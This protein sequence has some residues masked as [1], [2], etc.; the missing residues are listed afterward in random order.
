M[1]MRTADTTLTYLVSGPFLLIIDVHVAHK[2]SAAS[3]FCERNI[4]C[5]VI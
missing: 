3:E 2:T 1:T 4:M 5:Y